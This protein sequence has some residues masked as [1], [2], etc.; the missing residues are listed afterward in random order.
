MR[1]EALGYA[2]GVL[3][4]YQLYVTL[5]VLFARGYTG[6]QKAMQCAL[7]WLLPLAG[8]LLCH[9]LLGSDARISAR[10]DRAFI[11]DGGANPPGIGA[12]TPPL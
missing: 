10:R 9:G 12:G 5:R 2:A 1:I 3:A 11:P 7:I 4:L 6:P 8:A